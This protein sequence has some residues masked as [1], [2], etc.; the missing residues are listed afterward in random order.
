MHFGPHLAS[1]IL[2]MGNAAQNELPHIHKPMF[3][4]FYSADCKTCEQMKPGVQ[5]LEQE[6][7]EKI[8][9][10]Y[11]DSDDRRN[12]KLLSMFQVEG[13]PAFY[14]VTPD[15]EIMYFESGLVSLSR[16]RQMMND[17]AEHAERQESDAHE[18]HAPEK[19]TGEEI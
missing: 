2:G 14:W 1:S 5:K 8:E 6:F 11:V 19:D 7:F 4:E 3:V 13:L 15:R 12:R 10:L 17:L 9:F 16:M 18:E